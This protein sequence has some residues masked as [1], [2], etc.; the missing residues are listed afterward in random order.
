MSVIMLASIRII[1][2]RRALMAVIRFLSDASSGNLV[3]VLFIFIFN[4]SFL[5]L[6]DGEYLDCYCMKCF[7]FLGARNVS[8]VLKSR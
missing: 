6:G 5:L 8:E 3:P 2:R 1:P 7:C 4:A